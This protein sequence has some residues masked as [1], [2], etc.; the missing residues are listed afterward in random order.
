MGRFYRRQSLGAPWYES[1][2][3]VAGEVGAAVAEGYT[4][5]K[6][7][8]DA[9]RGLHK[10]WTG[11]VFNQQQQPQQQA[12][13]PQPQHA[14]PPLPPRPPPPRPPQPVYHP[15][16]PRPMYQPPAASILP[17]PKAGISGTTLLVIG[18]VGVAGV[19]AA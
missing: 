19:A 15:P 13:Q 8:G 12:P 18:A 11:A 10:G 5:Q 1:L 6:V 2:L 16:P 4:G 3:N 17:P 9:I 14:P 7:V